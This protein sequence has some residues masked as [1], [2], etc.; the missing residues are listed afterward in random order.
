MSKI[1]QKREAANM[2]Q[3]DLGKRLGVSSQAVCQWEAGTSA[4]KLSNLA[5]MAQIFGCAIDDLVDTRALVAPKGNFNA[6]EAI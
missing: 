2:S 5:A 3:V 4:P 6:T 1:R